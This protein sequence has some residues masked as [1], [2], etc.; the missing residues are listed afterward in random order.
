M[1]EYDDEA[2]GSLLGETSEIE[3][4]ADIE[5]FEDV[6]DDLLN[7]QQL[8][9]RHLEPRLDNLDVA[10]AFLRETISVDHLKCYQQEEDDDQKDSVSDLSEMELLSR[11]SP[12]DFWDCESIRSTYTNTENHPK[13]IRESP[14]KPIHLDAITGLPKIGLPRQI[15]K[16]QQSL[17]KFE[18]IHESRADLGL[19]R[20]KDENSEDKRARKQLIRQT[21]KVKFYL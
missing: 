6:L 4:V 18:P 1:R 2:V 8:V 13:L 3:G 17:P 9:G 11:H 14:A 10:R 21:R 20:S 7:R 19:A 12:S 16:Q 15:M 5:E